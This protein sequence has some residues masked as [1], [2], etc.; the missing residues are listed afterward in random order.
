MDK[1]NSGLSTGVSSFYPSPHNNSSY[2]PESKDSAA[3][4]AL[5]T[6]LRPPCRGQLD[7]GGIWQL[8]LFLAAGL[9]LLPTSLRAANPAY[10]QGNYSVP[11]WTQY[12]PPVQTSYTKAQVAGDLNVVVVG[13]SDSVAHVASVS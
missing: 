12:T 7:G 6:R 5:G 10:I 2:S 4:S 1:A 13:W 3:R 9:V 8:L 11:Q